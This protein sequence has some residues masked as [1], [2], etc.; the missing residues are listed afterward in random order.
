MNNVQKPLCWFCLCKSPAT[1]TG[2]HCSSFCAAQPRAHCEFRSPTT[3]LRLVRTDKRLSS[4]V[5]HHPSQQATSLSRKSESQRRL[6]MVAACIAHGLQESCAALA[7]EPQ[8][9]TSSDCP[10][11]LCPV[12]RL[13]SQAASHHDVLQQQVRALALA[14]DDDTTECRGCSSAADTAM[15][16]GASSTV[17]QAQ[18]HQE[19]Q[20]QG[21]AAPSACSNDLLGVGEQ[22]QQLDDQSDEYREGDGDVQGEDSDGGCGSSS[23]G[24]GKGGSKAVFKAQRKAA[25]KAA[26]AE[27]RE[28]R[29]SLR[30]GRPCDLCSKLVDTLIRCQVRGRE[31][32][33]G[34][35]VRRGKASILQV[36]DCKES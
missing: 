22:E 34:E 8:L 4:E 29:D 16:Q 24:G 17:A 33:G 10:A 13:E 26:K 31:E 9:S 19:E 20:H 35:R 1:Q 2:P 21:A 23:H 7:G 28:A 36:R 27:K 18:G 11:Q 14:P 25:K 12:T 32:T 6:R 15:L 5:L 30:G 3:L